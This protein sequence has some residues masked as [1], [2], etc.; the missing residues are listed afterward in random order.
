MYVLLFLYRNNNFLTCEQINNLICAKLFNFALN[1]NNA[2]RIIIKLTII[3]DF[4]DIF[5]F[6][7][8]YIIFVKRD[9][10]KICNKNFFKMF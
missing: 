1:A 6:I 10:A 2:L 7:A 4:C 8:L 5:N 9:F 3:Y